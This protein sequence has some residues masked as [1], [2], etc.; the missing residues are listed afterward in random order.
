VC[1]SAGDGWIETT[2]E[3]CGDNLVNGT[4][5]ECDGTDV[6]AQTCADRGLEDGTSGG[7]ELAC[8]TVSCTYDISTCDLCTDGFTGAKCLEGGTTTCANSAA[9]SDS[10]C[11][12]GGECTFTCGY[13]VSCTGMSCNQA[14]CNFGCAGNSDC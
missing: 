7:A 2:C 12:A 10:Q 5:E 3:Y 14:D 11:G 8:D 9:C 1:N 13:N 6:V 4:G